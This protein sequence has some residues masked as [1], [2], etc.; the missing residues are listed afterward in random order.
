[1][2]AKQYL[3]EIGSYRRVCVSLNEQIEDLRNQ[4]GGLRAIAYDKDRVQVSPANRMEELIPKLIKIEAELTD[5]LVKY[6]TEVLKRTQEISELSN[7]MHVTVLTARYCNGKKWEEIAVETGY[8]FRHILRIHGD[9]LQAFE[10][11]MS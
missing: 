6:N 8:T 9:A 11:K 5:A 7:P 10:R 4:I 2:R 1:M 3:L